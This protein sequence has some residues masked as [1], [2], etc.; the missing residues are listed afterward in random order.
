VVLALEGPPRV[1]VNADL[2]VGP[3]S[4]SDLLTLLRPMYTGCLDM[5]SFIECRHVN[6]I[7]LRVWYASC[8]DQCNLKAYDDTELNIPT[9]IDLFDLDLRRYRTR[10]MRFFFFVKVG[11]YTSELRWYIETA[12]VETVKFVSCYDNITRCSAL[13]WKPELW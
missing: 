3:R 1:W 12:A 9:F 13:R 10:S 5:W 8:A 4:W 7:W 6:W 11:C 2:I